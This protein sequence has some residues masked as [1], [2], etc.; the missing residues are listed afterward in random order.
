MT[1]A[2]T[3][4]AYLRT[5]VLTASPQELRLMLLDGAIRYAQMGRDGLA[6]RDFEQ[7]YNG[8]TQCRAIV[9]ELMTSIRREHDP[10]LA[11]RVQSVY[12]FLFNELINA[13]MEKDP[14]RMD[15]IIELLEFERETWAMLIEKLRAERAGAPAPAEGASSLSVQA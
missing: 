6:G 15:K 12:I 7:A 1:D 11:D 4:N 8:I 3:T 14:A 5:K 9:T 2:T 13:S 10:Q